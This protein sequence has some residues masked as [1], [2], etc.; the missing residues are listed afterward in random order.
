M[1]TILLNSFLGCNHDNS[2]KGKLVLSDTLIAIKQREIDSKN[3]EIAK[4]NE[5]IQ[6][7]EQRDSALIIDYV[8]HQNVYKPIYDRLKNIPAHIISISGD[9]ERIRAAFA[10]H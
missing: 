2:Y 6:R 1:G 5:I 3:I 7:S 4:L 9:D 8:T 10:N